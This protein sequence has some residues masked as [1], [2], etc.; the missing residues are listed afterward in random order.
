MVAKILVGWQDIL[1]TL[2]EEIN[3]EDIPAEYGGNFQ[4]GVYDSK[5]ERDL[6]ALVDKLN[7]QD[8]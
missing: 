4:G 7:K 3:M 5:I 1:T 2:T 8:A 6:Q